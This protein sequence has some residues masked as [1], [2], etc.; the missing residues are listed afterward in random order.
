M[1]SEMRRSA[2]ALV[3]HRSES[4]ASRHP[5]EESRARLA[6]A[7]E[8]AKIP[9]SPQFRAAWR[10]DDGRAVL[11]AEFAPSPRSQRLLKLTSIVMLLLMV[12]SAW[13]L[14]SPTEEPTLRFM[15]PMFTVLAI[16]G[17]PFFALALASQR[18][19]AEARIRKAIRV[20]LLE[21][22]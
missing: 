17:A 6:E 2:R 3:E 7:L 1:A 16:L 5:L 11:D 14:L 4:F 18:E 20:A 10:S 12:G 9:A 22:A 21:E 19:A 13:A 15:V 8:R